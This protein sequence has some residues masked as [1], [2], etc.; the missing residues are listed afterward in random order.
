M[1]YI[2]KLRTSSRLVLVAITFIV[3]ACASEKLEIWRQIPIQMTR[4]SQ[5]E[6]FTQTF[7]LKAPSIQEKEISARDKALDERMDNIFTNMAGAK[8]WQ[9]LKNLYGIS[10]V[11]NEL[12][13][14]DIHMDG[15]FNFNVYL[16]PTDFDYLVLE[17]SGR[18]FAIRD[19]TDAILMSGDF[20]M[21]P[22]R[23]SIAFM[24]EGCLPLDIKLYITRIPGRTTYYKD[25]M[26]RYDLIIDTSNAADTAYAIDYASDHFAFLDLNHDGKF[27]PQ[28]ELFASLK[29]NGLHRQAKLFDI[30]GLLFV[31]QNYDISA[32]AKLATAIS[33]KKERRCVK[34]T[35]F[36]P[37][38][39]GN[40]EGAS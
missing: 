34:D 32:E 7:L 15:L 8:N 33:G 40:S 13:N 22:Q 25:I 16:D 19:K 24:S 35:P 14:G 17:G 11:R 28:E 9:L 12:M 4:V 39:T 37:S 23:Y 6:S 5:T 18:F 38:E 20:H 21:P 36:T 1:P 27:D 10:S 26:V 2:Q 30:R 29:M 3:T 31:K